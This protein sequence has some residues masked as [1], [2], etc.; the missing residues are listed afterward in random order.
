MFRTVLAIVLLPLLG[1]CVTMP[2][3]PSDEDI[4]KG[5]TAPTTP[6]QP[7]LSG[8]LTD[9][10]T[11]APVVGAS[12]TVQS[13]TVTSSVTGHYLFDP[14]LVGGLFPVTI[15]H[16]SYKDVTSDVE[17]APYKWMDFKLQPR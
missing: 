4:A 6:A 17:I 7:S 5:L 10:T 8:R 1:G 16:P 11:G 2:G 14:N 12:V 9:A 13:R 15:S 3:A